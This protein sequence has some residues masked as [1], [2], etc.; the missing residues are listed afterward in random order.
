MD[1]V[2]LKYNT[3]DPPVANF[4]IQQF[5]DTAEQVGGRLM[6]KIKT[7]QGELLLDSQWWE[8][9]DHLQSGMETTLVEYARL[10]NSL[11]AECPIKKVSQYSRVPL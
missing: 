11:G 7:D 4:R 8:L 10:L 9:P 5:K 3:C 2:R 1:Q 6:Y